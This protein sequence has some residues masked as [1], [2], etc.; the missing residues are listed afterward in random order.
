VQ[1]RPSAASEDGCH[2]ARWSSQRKGQLVI[3]THTGQTVTSYPITHITQGPGPELL[4]DT[5][6]LAYPGAEWEEEPPGHWSIHVFTFT[7]RGRS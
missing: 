4:W 3:T 2:L 7:S 6:W 1:G 5:G